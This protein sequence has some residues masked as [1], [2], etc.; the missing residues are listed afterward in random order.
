MNDFDY[1]LPW[2]H[3]SDQQLTS[4]RV[5]SSITQLRDLARA[6]SHRPTL[7]AQSEGGSVRHNGERPGYLYRVAEEL[8]PDD[9]YA[10]PH[11]INA[12][13]W[14]WQITREV[15]VELLEV[16]EVRADELLTD[17]EI[18]WIRREQQERGEQ[19]FVSDEPANKGTKE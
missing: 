4:L 2:Y 1:S 7:L 3:G 18:A 10:H 12:T 6:F 8:Q 14:E 19:S 9:I 16:T 17:E 13:R 15:A 11:P 5:G